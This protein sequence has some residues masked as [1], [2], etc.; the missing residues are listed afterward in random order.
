MEWNF[1]GRVGGIYMHDYSLKA[2]G[3]NVFR[4]RH[5]IPEII[6]CIGVG[7]FDCRAGHD[8]VKLVE[9]QFFPRL[10]QPAV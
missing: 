10:S 1:K 7:R 3:L 5:G 9:Q 2:F 4:F 6:M 8:V